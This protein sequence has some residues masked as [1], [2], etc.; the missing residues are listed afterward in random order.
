MMN[1]KPRT[2]FWKIIHS[3]ILVGTLVV[4]L[5]RGNLQPVGARETAS[6]AQ[7][8]LIPHPFNYHKPLCPPVAKPGL[9]RC[10]SEIVTN[11]FGGPIVSNSLL[12]GSYGPAAFR[13]AYGIS[14]TTATN[15]IVAIVD[16]YDN[17]TILDDLDTYS[18][19]F[20]IPRLNRCAVSTGTAASPCIQK[21]DQNGG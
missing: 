19:H 12:T 6:S 10:S 14:G 16:A 7:V 3:I 11:A 5:G 21:V 17:P 8:Q 4:A 20:G 18:D 13:G 9:A 2:R 15:R 1:F